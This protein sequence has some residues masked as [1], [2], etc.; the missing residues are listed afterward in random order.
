MIGTWS[1]ASLDQS[2]EVVVRVRVCRT[3]DWETAE[4][5]RAEPAAGRLPESSET[6]S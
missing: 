3:D 2:P 1:P 5:W 6:V 4:L